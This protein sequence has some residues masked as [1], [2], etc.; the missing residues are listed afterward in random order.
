MDRD[1]LLARILDQTRAIQTLALAGDWILAQQQDDTR[2]RMIQDCFAA[3]NEFANPE[4]AAITIQEILNLDRHTLE[5]GLTAR[6]GLRAEFGKLR[7]GRVARTAY[8]RVSQD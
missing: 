5:L 1:A 6:D 4:Q 3:S 2:R 8:G 7:Q